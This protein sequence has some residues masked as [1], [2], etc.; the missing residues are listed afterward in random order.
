MSL[1]HCFKRY[2]VCRSYYVQNRKINIVCGLSIDDEGESKGHSYRNPRF[3]KCIKQEEV[4]MIVFQ[5]ND[6]LCKHSSGTRN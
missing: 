3:L 1:S 4:R 6:T 2:I 5:L